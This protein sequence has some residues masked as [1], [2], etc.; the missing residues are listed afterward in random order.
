VPSRKSGLTLIELL[1]VITVISVLVAFLL[2]AL[3]S[4]VETAR[5]VHC[6]NSQKQILVADLLYASDCHGWMYLIY[7]HG[8]PKPSIAWEDVTHDLDAYRPTSYLDDYRDLWADEIRWC[9]TLIDACGP[10]TWDT[11]SPQTVDNRF[12]EWVYSRP[13]IQDD[14]VAACDAGRVSADKLYVNPAKRTPA[15]SASGIYQYWQNSTSKKADLTGTAPMVS[16]YFYKNTT[17]LY[18]SVTA[19]NGYSAKSGDWRKPEGANSGWLDG[20]VQWNNWTKILDY[21]F[22]DK[23]QW[24]RRLAFGGPSYEQGFVWHMP[25]TGTWAF[26]A[27]RGQPWTR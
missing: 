4:A 23:T 16:D 14:V 11:V 21:Y 27:R 19:H 3:R 6:M 17:Y 9:P 26:Y 2:P 20:H 15:I 13:G 12:G 25:T 18:K 7:S 22:C 5:R 1:I 24:D 8:G 10:G